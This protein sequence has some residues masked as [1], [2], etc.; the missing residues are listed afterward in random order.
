ML[1]DIGGK[2]SPF[3][4]E[5]VLAAY[6]LSFYRAMTRREIPVRE[7]GMTLYKSF[8]YYLTTLP[9]L[10]RRLMGM[11]SLSYFMKR[12]YERGV[13]A[14][15]VGTYPA[16]FVYG[17]VRGD[18]KA[19]DYGLD[20]TECALLKFFTAQ[21]VGEFT[22]YLCITDYCVCRSLGV[23]FSRTSTLASGGTTCDFRFTRGGDTAQGWPPET[24]PEWKA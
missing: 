23:G 8:E 1:P 22:P 20:I 16:G 3:I 4:E 18:G 21:G 11:W 5:M 13:T 14:C 10:L 24:L 6:A 2:K 9:G 19:F 15:D 12:K 17:Y 7:I